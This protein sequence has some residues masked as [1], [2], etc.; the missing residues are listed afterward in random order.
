MDR[1]AENLEQKQGPLRFLVRSGPLFLSL[2]GLSAA[3]AVVAVWEVVAPR[4][5]LTDCKGRRWFANLSMVV[6]DTAAVRL[7]LPVLPVGMALMSQE[8]DWGILN[9]VMLPARIEIVL[10][11][12]ALDFV[13][14]LQ[15]VLFHFLP[16]LWRRLRQSSITP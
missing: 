4:R 2:P 10:A 6:I 14:Y 13:I 8:R 9:L 15:Y 16:I 7:L 11:I 12:V 5:T 1:A 3:P